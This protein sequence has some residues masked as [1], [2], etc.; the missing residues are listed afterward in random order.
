MRLRKADNVTFKA[1]H[2]SMAPVRIGYHKPPFTFSTILPFMKVWVR[3]L[4]IFDAQ[5]SNPGCRRW[6]D[7]G[8]QSEGSLSLYVSRG[9]RLLLE[10]LDAPP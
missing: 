2:A 3:G 10:T 5:I 4:S 6:R 7:T 8:I 1:L 9:I